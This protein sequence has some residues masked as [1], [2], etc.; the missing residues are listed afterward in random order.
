MNVAASDDLRSAIVKI[1]KELLRELNQIDSDSGILPWHSKAKS[2]QLTSTA[3][4]PL[5]VT[6]LHCYMHKLYVPS[7]GDRSTLYPHICIGHDVDFK[8]IREDIFPWVNIYNHGIFYNMLQVED[9]T[10]IGW[11]LYHT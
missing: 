3:A 8:T 6:G 5:T 7:K 2:E 11:L 1:L 10:G 9:I 4:M